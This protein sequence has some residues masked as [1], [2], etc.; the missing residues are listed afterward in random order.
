MVEAWGTFIFKKSY[1]YRTSAYIQWGAS[2]APLGAVLMLNPGSA[3]LHSPAGISQKPYKGLINLDPTMMELVDLV[4]R[5]NPGVQVEG[6]LYIYNLFSLQNSKGEN[7]LK[8]FEQLWEDEEKLVKELPENRSVLLSQFKTYPWVL[9]GWGCGQRSENILNLKKQWYSILKDSGVCIAGKCGQSEWD[10]YHPC[11]RLA[12]KKEEYKIEILKQLEIIQ[13]LTSREKD[14][15]IDDTSQK[16]NKK[17]NF[18][19][20]MEKTYF[21]NKIEQ[22]EQVVTDKH[23]N[24]TNSNNVINIGDIRGNRREI[25][26]KSIREYDDRYEYCIISEYE[27]KYQKFEAHSIQLNDVFSVILE[28][29]NKMVLV[30]IEFYKNKFTIDQMITWLEFYKIYVGQMGEKP[31]TISDCSKVIAGLKFKGNILVLYQKGHNIIQLPESDYLEITDFFIS[32]LQ[33]INTGKTKGLQKGLIIRVNDEIV[34]EIPRFD[35]DMSRDIIIS[36]GNC[37]NAD[38][39]DEYSGG[40]GF[41][42]EGD[43]AIPVA[44]LLDNNTTVDIEI[45]QRED[46]SRICVVTHRYLI[47][48][49]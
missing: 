3:S 43:S 45:T 25:L 46:G 30:S 44:F 35:F 18:I 15:S 23:I 47:E 7:A 17:G 22:C 40:I 42:Q 5:H 38:Y 34:S 27:E 29:N 9:I 16:N 39:I 2:K 12:E 49:D 4:E 32:N 6:R 10:Y 24:N 26:T 36:N 13:P 21:G 48:V 41:Y 37:I 1:V 20:K 11:Q 14:K 31:Y 8:I 19:Q 33:E 28:V